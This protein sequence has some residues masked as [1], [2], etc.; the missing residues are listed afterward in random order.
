MQPQANTA[1]NALKTAVFCSDASPREKHTTAR[2][3]RLVRPSWL[4]RNSRHSVFKPRKVTFRAIFFHQAQLSQIADRRAAHPRF[5]AIQGP[6]AI[7][8][9]LLASA[10]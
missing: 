10:R 9:F 6:G 3:A 1:F 7:S 4:R 5:T 8:F 2:E